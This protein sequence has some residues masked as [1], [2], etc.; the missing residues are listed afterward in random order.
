MG[1]AFV[2]DDFGATVMGFAFVIGYLGANYHRVDGEP[3]HPTHKK[4]APKEPFFC[5][6]TL[7]SGQ[8]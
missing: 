4:M 8:A 6:S 2:I 5:R 3:V 7:R 1:F